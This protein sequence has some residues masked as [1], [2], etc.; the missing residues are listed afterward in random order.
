MRE[1]KVIKVSQDEPRK[2]DG[3]N[4]TVYYIKVRLEGHDKPVSIGKKS[5]DAIK[6]GDTVFGEVQATEYEQDKFKAGQKPFG[7]ARQS[8]DDSARRAQ[9]AIGQAIQVHLSNPAH[10]NTIDM[11]GIEKFAEALVAMVDRV[12]ES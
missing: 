3:P 12:K 7:G 1:W 11:P 9:W 10:D 6:E 4:G 2:W 5:P 8:R